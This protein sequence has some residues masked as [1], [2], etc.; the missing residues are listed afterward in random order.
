MSGDVFGNG[1]LLSQHIRLVG[2]FNHLHIFVDPDPDP[3]ASFAERQRLFDL[4]RSSWTDYDPAKLSAGGAV[5]DR[6]AKSIDVSA[7]VRAR[8]GAR[9]SRRVDPD[10]LIR[11]MLSADVELLWFGGIGT[12]VKASG[13]THGDVGDRA[14]DELRVDAPELRAKVVGEGANLGL[15]QR[16]RIE[17]APAAAASTPTPSTTPPASTAPTTRST[18]R[19]CF[20]DVMA[21]DGMDLEQRNRLL[22]E[23]TDE[24]G[25]LVLRDNYL[26]TQAISVAEAQGGG[27][28][29][30][31]VAADPQRSS[32]RGGST[33]QARVPA[34]RR[35]SSP[36]ARP[37]G[38]A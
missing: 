30:R 3:A 10:E 28:A 5:F 1:M 26:Q 21:R 12:Y 19:S 24:V 32:G 20:G 8:F 15:T 11:A 37:R 13:E 33:A 23:M 16:G 25:Q 22:A 35:G 2:A 4:P 17:F 9:P 7:E 31:P 36:S 27:A 14:N 18:S 34:R 29:R 6:S 38:A